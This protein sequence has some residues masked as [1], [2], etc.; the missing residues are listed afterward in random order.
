MANLI[1]TSLHTKSA[2]G[3]THWSVRTEAAE[4]GISKSSVVRYFQLFGLQ[5]H[6]SESCKLSRPT[7]SS[8][9]SCAMWPGCT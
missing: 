6:R 3:L 2:N 9:R 7:R 1:K 8:S 5:L 4:A